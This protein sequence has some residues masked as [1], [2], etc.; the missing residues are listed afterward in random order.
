MNPN[1]FLK[2]ELQYELG[3]RGIRSDDNVQTLRKLFRSVV[4]RDLPVELRYLHSLGIEE[5]YGNLAS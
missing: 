3:V 4:S 5:L 1:F 2:A